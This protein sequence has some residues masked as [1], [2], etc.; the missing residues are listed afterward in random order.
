MLS[1]LNIIMSC[2][3]NVLELRLILMNHLQ[4]FILLL[5][6]II[7]LNLA[8]VRDI[9]LVYHYSLVVWVIYVARI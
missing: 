6:L 3:Q 8:F 1:Q 9:H 2:F 5:Q 7:H 4:L